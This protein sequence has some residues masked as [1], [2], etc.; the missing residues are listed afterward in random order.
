MQYVPGNPSGDGWVGVVTNQN[1]GGGVGTALAGN[2]SMTD[3]EIQAQIY[4][5][6]SSSA[7]G[8]YHAVVARWD[9]TTGSTSGQS[10]YSFRTDFDTD[11]RVQLCKYPSGMG[12]SLIIAQ[13]VGNQ[14]PGGVPTQNSWHLM[15]LKCLGDQLWVYWDGA[16]LS[17]CPYADTSLTHGF[18]G[19]HVFR[20]SGAAQTL[21]DDILV[22]AT[23][24]P[25]KRQSL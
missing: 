10:Y 17:G 23:R 16:M 13:W 22:L 5:T 19:C 12:G 25:L 14:I 6:V 21:C 20:L 7:G 1:S 11:Q 18:F 9:T 24:Q 4:C 15:A 8:T 2:I 3:Y